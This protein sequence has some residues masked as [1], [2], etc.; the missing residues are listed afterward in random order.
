MVVV[1]S[2]TP[3]TTDVRAFRKRGATGYGWVPLVLTPELLATI[4]GHNERVE[5]KGFE[6]AVEL[7]TEAVKRASS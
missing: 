6:R 7:M 1:P 2:L 5:V 4:H 3:G